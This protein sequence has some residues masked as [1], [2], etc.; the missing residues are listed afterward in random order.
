MASEH[1][2]L[3]KDLIDNYLE[4]LENPEL[5]DFKMNIKLTLDEPFYFKPRRLSWEE[6]VK[7]REIIDKLL[8]LGCIRVSKSNYSSPIVLTRK[9]NVELRLCIDYNVLN[10]LIILEHFPL[11]LIDDLIDLLQGKAYFTKLDLRD[12]FHHIKINEN[13]VKYTAFSTPEG[14]YQY[15]RMPFGLVNAPSYFQRYLSMIFHELLSKG[16]LLMYLDDF[17]IPPK[18]LKENFEILREVLKLMAKN[19]LRLRIDKCV[20]GVTKIEYLGYVISENKVEPSHDHVKA[21]STY[22][23]PRSVTQVQKFLGLVGFVR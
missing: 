3:L 1:K 5:M 22:P 14:Q 7:L 15:L 19:G 6:K 2:A 8:K 20:F 13:S 18:T 16:L 17:L 23:I 10:K 9:K 4:K 12:W 11:P 21:L